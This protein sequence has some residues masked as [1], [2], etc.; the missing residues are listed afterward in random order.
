MSSS[1]TT[2]SRGEAESART[3]T[4]SQLTICACLASA[5]EKLNGLAVS[6]RTF[7]PL[8]AKFDTPMDRI[9][10]AGGESME[11][12]GKTPH[13]A[14]REPGAGWSAA[15]RVCEHYLLLMFSG[16]IAAW[17]VCWPIAQGLGHGPVL[18]LAKG[19]PVW[20]LQI[21]AMLVPAYYGL[22]CTNPRRAFGG[23]LAFATA[24]LGATFWWLFVALHTYGGLPV[25]VTVLSITAL[26]AALGLYYAA[27][28]WLF[29]CLRTRGDWLAQPAFVALWIMAELARATWMTGFGWGAMAYAH[30]DGPLAA[31]A[32]W[33]GVYGVGA[34]AAWLAV[35]MAQSLLL[36]RPHRA[37]PALGVMAL[38]VF[39]PHADFTSS[40][41][42]IPVVLLQ[43]DIPQDEKFVAGTGIANSLQWYGEQLIPDQAALYVAP[44]TALPELPQDL[45]AG[46]LEGLV[47]KFSDGKAALLTG[48]PLGDDSRGYR[49]AVIGIG[50]GGDVPYTYAKHHL[51]PFGEFIPPLFKWFTRMMNI[52]LGDFDRGG[53]GQ[54]AFVWQGQRL[55]PNICYE[56]L[57]GEELGTRFQRAEN[58]PTIFVNVSNLGWFGDTIAIDQHL[59]ISRMRA[60]EFQRPFLRATNT[61]ATMIMDY[62]GH[63]AAALPYM[64]RAVLKGEVQ[65]RTGNTPYASWVA[66][67]GLWPVWLLA[68][69]ITALAWKR[70]R[71]AEGAP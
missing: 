15:W 7:R 41:G 20:W 9:T 66:R 25:S 55:G 31:L 69:A 44:E 11:K 71:Q 27:A 39:L 12:T 56:D 58:A 35:A 65:G 1:R 54:P 17:A 5:V 30:T 2:S 42:S 68:L 33:V 6:R 4:A 60:L 37:V 43:G 53:L 3:E 23:G 40:T 47:A 36:R 16:V 32:P 28:A 46:Y 48:I 70:R 64:T 50:D 24:W 67:F 10:Q 14:V 29:V 8:A 22:A 45:P 38:L 19:L 13:L 62:E 49:N 57:Y 52:P 26:A 34:V 21:L 59:Q 51:V 63:T 61:G 18:G